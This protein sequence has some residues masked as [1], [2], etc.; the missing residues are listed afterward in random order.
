M[1]S[2]SSSLLEGFHGRIRELLHHPYPLAE[3]TVNV[4]QPRIIP[5]SPDARALWIGFVDYVE[6]RLAP[7]GE[8]RLISGLANKLPEHAARLAGIM[9]VYD[10]SH[11]EHV[12]AEHMK[13]GIVLAKHFAAETLRLRGIASVYLPLQHA[14]ELLEW[15]HK[16]WDEP[17]ISLADIYQG[18]PTFIRSAEMARTVVET[19]VKHRWL[20]AVKGGAPVKG[21]HRREVWRIAKL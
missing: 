16:K 11:A 14:Q 13:R 8:Y 4:L 6:V 21:K 1:T 18:G 5:L 3:G 20:I 17:V 2:R 7:H 9:A 10:D 19:L 15:L 12:E